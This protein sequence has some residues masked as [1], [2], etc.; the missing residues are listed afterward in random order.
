MLQLVVLIA[1]TTYSAKLEATETCTRLTF[2]SEFL[3]IER[4]INRTIQEVQNERDALV[5]FWKV[6]AKLK[7]CP[8]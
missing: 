3:A 6:C 7:T 8:H 5:D 4:S 2:G 1:E